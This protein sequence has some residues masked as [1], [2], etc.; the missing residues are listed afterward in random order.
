MKK[1]V[2]VIAVFLCVAVLSTA[3]GEDHTYF[4]AYGSVIDA[5]FS[6][7]GLSDDGGYNALYE[8]VAR[9][10]FD[11]YVSALRT[12]HF[13]PYSFDYKGMECYYAYSVRLESGAVLVYDE[14]QLTL[15]IS[16]DENV[17]PVEAYDETQQAIAE[18]DGISLTIPSDAKGI[19]L[20]QFY[21]FVNSQ[22]DIGWQGQVQM[23]SI[24]DGQQCW[25]EHYSNI[26]PKIFDQ[27]LL[28]MYALGCDLM[29][30][31]VGFDD[32]HAVHVI[33]IDLVQDDITLVK[34]T[35]YPQ[36]SSA[37]VNY[38]PNVSFDLQNEEQMIA[39]IQR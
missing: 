7:V 12:L 11:T 8:N 20:P 15:E 4:L 32:D 18:N 28:I 9:E 1:W 23:D 39:M 21:A 33:R 29:G 19:V 34:L 5:T 30:N 37:F 10:D 35:Y 13:I 16:T 6:D 36:D 38:N 17:V 26:T 14:D 24:F 3:V 22:E 25:E 2:G 27:Y 31:Y